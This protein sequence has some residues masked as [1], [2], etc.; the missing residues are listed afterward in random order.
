MKKRT[1]LALSV[2]LFVVVSIYTTVRADQTEEQEDDNIVFIQAPNSTDME[3]Y[4]TYEIN[5]DGPKTCTITAYTG[6]FYSNI[7][8]ETLKEYTVTRIGARAFKNVNKITGGLTLPSSLIS[9]GD[10]AFSGCTLITSITLSSTT[11]T[12]G[13]KAFEGCTA[14]MKINVENV[15]SIGNEAFKGCSG[16]KGIS[17]FTFSDK[18]HSIGSRAFAGCAVPQ[19]EFTSATAPQVN[20]DTFQD[21][22]GKVIIPQQDSEYMG[23]AWVGAYVKGVNKIGDLDG[24]GVVD[25]NDA[26]LVLERYKNESATK[27]EIQIADIDRNGLLDANDASLILEIFKTNA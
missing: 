27:R 20:N 1:I 24:N 23:Q 25:A 2:M 15:E 21:Y 12:I 17:S 7:I 9:I 13:N 10:E 4:Y 26:S 11:K 22:E 18:I 5:N 3:K 14:I 16:I 6:E 19:I 8:P